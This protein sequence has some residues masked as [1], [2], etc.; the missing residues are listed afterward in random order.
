MFVVQPQSSAESRNFYT[1]LI[2]GFLIIFVSEIADKTF[3]LI[4]I[5]T[6]KLSVFPLFVTSLL[7][8]IFMN[9][10]AISVGF[11]VPMLV[12]KDVVDWLGI[13]CFSVF[14]V[15]SIYSGL[16]M[17]SKK[18]SDD[19]EEEENRQ[20][21]EYISLRESR[22]KLGK[23]TEEADQRPGT[24]GLCL[25]LCGLLILNELGDRSQITTITIS[26]IY[27]ITGVFIGTSLAYLAAITIAIALGKII[28]VY[29]T[30]KHMTIIGGVVFILF[31][32][33]IIFCK[34]PLF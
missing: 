18:L 27:D 1:S 21:E 30:E 22:K 3:I 14:G 29:I 24:W 10:L 2:Q 26:A 19:I 31:A 32:L 7:T 20:E 17:E 13:L 25:S 11:L 28:S 9:I 34:Y 5:Y 12:V 16:M 33:M 8:M 15:Y 6:S 4:V 23:E